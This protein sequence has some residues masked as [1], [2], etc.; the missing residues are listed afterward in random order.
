MQLVAYQNGERIDA[1]AMEHDPWRAL[2]TSPGYK[3]LTFLEC[4]MRAKRVTRKSRQCFAHLPSATCEVDHKSESHQHLVMKQALAERINATPGWRAQVEYAAPGL[5]WIA[6]VMGFDDHGRRLAFEVQLSAQNE[7]D[8]IY[9]SQRYFEAGIGVVWMVPRQLDWRMVRLPVVVSGFGKTSDLP[10]KSMELMS[11]REFQPIFVGTMDVGTA[12]DGI[13][14][15]GF[16]WPHGSPEAQ[17]LRH[18]SDLKAA[19]DREE[20][21]R[22]KAERETV[23]RARK[24]QEQEETSARFLALQRAAF[25]DSAIPAAEVAVVP[26]ATAGVNLWASVIRCANARHPV[27]IW[28]VGNPP[29][30]I[31]NPE[32]WRPVTENFSNVQ[33][34]VDGWIAA[35]KAPVWKGKLVPVKGPGKKLAFACPSCNDIIQGLL[36]A[37]LP[38]EKWTLI[39]GPEERATYTQQPTQRMQPPAPRNDYPRPRVIVPITVARYPSPDLIPAPIGPAEKPFWISEAQN[40]KQIAERQAAKDKRAAQIQEIRDSPRYRSLPSGFR[41]QCTDCHGV[42]EVDNEGLHAEAGC[43]TRPMR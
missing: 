11:R 8:Y 42:F 20:R 22:L 38:P 24:R 6:D 1:T 27:L 33:R 23:E 26:M 15:P 35:A 17:K 3:D 37:V 28:R 5:V 25:R 16:S 30:P 32:S 7:D 12:I 41:F 31:K 18:L 14:H 43:I 40:D 4:G 39:G 21:L 19:Q 10:Q 34:N 9:R 29:V 13:L 36:I 2:P